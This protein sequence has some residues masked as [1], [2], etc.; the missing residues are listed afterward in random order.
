MIA[1]ALTLSLMT[2]CTTWFVR[3]IDPRLTVDCKAPEIRGK[4]VKDALVQSME[5]K[6]ALTECTCRMRAIRGDDLSD[7]VDVKK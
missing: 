3:D 2:G 7:C 1:V 4:T 6:E 5:R